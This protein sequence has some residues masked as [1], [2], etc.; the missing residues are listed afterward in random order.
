MIG[1]V[2]FLYKSRER[3]KNNFLI[4]PAIHFLDFVSFLKDFFGGM[5]GK[6]NVG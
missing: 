5:R 1:F 3:N 6:K 4:E 2:S